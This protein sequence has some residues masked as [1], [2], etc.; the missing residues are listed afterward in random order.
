MGE[1]T[2]AFQ[3]NATRANV[4]G[5]VMFPESAHSVYRERVSPAHLK[6]STKCRPISPPSPMPALEG[7]LRTRSLL[8]P[9]Q[10]EVLQWPLFGEL[11]VDNTP[12]LGGP[13]LLT[14]PH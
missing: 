3:G 11:Q 13:Q 1:K 10:G 2:R 9:P 6:R 12:K 5:R 4:H 7:N 14:S 8:A